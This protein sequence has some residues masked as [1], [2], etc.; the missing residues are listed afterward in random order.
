MRDGYHA[1]RGAIV[2]VK[3]KRGSKTTGRKRSVSNPSARGMA[4]PLPV[5]GG[6]V[7][8]TGLPADLEDIF[9]RR[10]TAVF[11]HLIESAGGITSA[12]RTADLRPQTLLSWRSQGPGD[13]VGRKPRYEPYRS[14]WIGYPPPLPAMDRIVERCRED[15]AG[16]LRALEDKHG[17]LSAAMTWLRS[18]GRR[19]GLLDTGI[20]QEKLTSAGKGRIPATTFYRILA[21]KNP[22][23]EVWRHL[24][25]LAMADGHEGFLEAVLSCASWR[26]RSSIPKGALAVL[27]ELAQ[28]KSEA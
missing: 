28:K 4:T 8:P 5:T 15:G 18:P 25:L 21:S 20:D 10:G 14:L 24:D 3:K 23:P 13:V 2:A 7:A 12:A 16:F 19:F 26:I 17:S 22:Y 11:E 6:P 1:T 27:I 9:M